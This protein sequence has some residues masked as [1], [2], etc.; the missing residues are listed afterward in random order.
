M[1]E[2]L[3]LREQERAKNS[4]SREELFKILVTWSVPVTHLTEI[5]RRKR[6]EIVDHFHRQSAQQLIHA[7][8]VGKKVRAARQAATVSSKRKFKGAAKMMSKTSSRPAVQSPQEIENFEEIECIRRLS[9]KPPNQMTLA[10]EQEAF[11]RT[12]LKSRSQFVSSK[13][14]LEKVVSFNPHIVEIV[15][16]PH[17][18][19]ICVSDSTRLL[20]VPNEA[21][22]TGL[23]PRGYSFSQSQ[24]NK[25]PTVSYADNSDTA[26]KLY[27]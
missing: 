14:L 12:C 22:R 24:T 3:R 25:S 1:V 26:V 6:H 10:A 7:M 19:D 16:I 13:K 21:L 11:V 23:R 27:H 4:L 15:C 8:F 17:P 2:Q 18:A 20:V 5:E 9:S